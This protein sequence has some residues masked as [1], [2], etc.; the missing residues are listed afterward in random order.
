MYHEEQSKMSIVEV[1]E[2][3]YDN[4]KTL[5][6]LFVKKELRLKCIAVWCPAIVLR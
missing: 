2:T 1:R 5:H 6:I 4:P 3:Q